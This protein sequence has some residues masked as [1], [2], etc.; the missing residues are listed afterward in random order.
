MCGLLPSGKRFQFPIEHGPVEIVDLPIT[1]GGSVCFVFVNVYQAGYHEISKIPTYQDCCQSYTRYFSA[2]IVTCCYISVIYN[3]LPYQKSPVVIYQLPELYQVPGLY[4]NI[5]GFLAKSSPFQR[6]NTHHAPEASA[7]SAKERLVFSFSEP[8]NWKVFCFIFRLEHSFFHWFIWIWLWFVISSLIYMD[9]MVIC[10]FFIDL[11]GYDG[12]LSFF[13]WFIWIW[14]WFVIFSL[15]YMDMMVICHF[16]I[17][18]YGYDGDLSFFH[19]FIWIWWWFVIFSLIY[20][21]MMVICH[22]FI[23]LYGYD[24]DLSFFHWFIW[25]WWWFVIFSLIYMDMMVICHFFIDLYGYDLVGGFNLAL[26]KMMD[27]VSWDD[28]IPNSLESH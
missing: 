23:D 4:P 26:W 25:I 15:I 6:K 10:H 8:K 9:M 24:G 20:M 22:F 14:W 5:C 17:D 12:D 18:L 13:H 2:V 21:D 11:Y 27:F 1:N 28:D 3:H 19:W 7:T 16:F